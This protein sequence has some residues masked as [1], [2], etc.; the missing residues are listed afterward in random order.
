MTST[1]SFS[2]Q[3][4]DDRDADAVQAAGDRV[5]AAAELAAGVQHRQHD[6]DGGAAVLG[7][8]DRLDR[9]ATAVVETLTEP[10]AW[11]VTTILSANPAMASSIALSTTSLTRWCRPRELVVPMYMPGR[12]RTGSSPSRTWMLLESYVAVR[13]LVL[14]LPTGLRS[15]VLDVRRNLRHA[16]PHHCRSGSARGEVARTP[17][18]YRRR[19][20][21]DRSGR[22]KTALYL[23]ISHRRRAPGAT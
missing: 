16:E 6:L 21:L 3:G 19:A 18:S 1:S 12:L 20:T 14:P 22:R 9:D 2:R 13:F 11:I 5:A 10:S 7:A 17:S 4:V 23:R 15:T 8:G